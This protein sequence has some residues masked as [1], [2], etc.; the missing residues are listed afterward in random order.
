MLVSFSVQ[1]RSAITTNKVNLLDGRIVFYDTTTTVI[2]I[3]RKP[4]AMIDERTEDSLEP[5][6]N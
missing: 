4:S 2:K 6:I 5:P 3:C 1:D